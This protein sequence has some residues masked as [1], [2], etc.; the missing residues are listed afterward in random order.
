MKNRNQVIDIFNNSDNIYGRRCKLVL[1]SPAGTEGI[2]FS[3]IRQVHIMEPYWHEVRITQMIGR[4]IRL[5]SHKSLPIDQ[6]V[7]TVY[8]YKSTRPEKTTT[9]QYIENLARRK[10][11]LINSFLDTIKE[12]AV[13]CELFKNHNR[14]KGDYKCFQFEEESLFDEKIAPAYKEDDVD[15]Y[16]LDNGLNSPKSAVQRIKVIKI[17]AVIQLGKKIEEQKFTKPENY[18]FNPDTKIVYDYDL[19][20]PLGKVGVN[21]NDYPLKLDENTYIIDKLIPIPRL[22]KNT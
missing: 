18:W 17:T 19:Q 13:D 20:F 11:G 22:T 12:A 21:E 7:V 16:Y 2:S 6:R 15:D 14:L 1:I 8:R 4:A 5:C 10:S 3:N 9:D